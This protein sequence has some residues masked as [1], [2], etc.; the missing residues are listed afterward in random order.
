MSG[1]FVGD[2]LTRLA[3]SS[4]TA[5]HGRDRQEGGFTNGPKA[6]R[7]SQEVHQ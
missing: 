3:E 1:Y 5:F 4:F 6:Q 7:N 2:R